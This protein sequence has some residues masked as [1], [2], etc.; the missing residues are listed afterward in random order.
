MRREQRAQSRKSVNFRV[1]TA[2]GEDQG[3]GTLID[4]SLSGA[5]IESSTFRPRL[6]APVKIVITT[7]RESASEEIV[8]TVA[9]HAPGGFAIHFAKTTPL[10]RRLVERGKLGL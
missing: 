7:D 3:E 4:I 1:L 5:L 6:G 10:V 9:R 8:G 2:S